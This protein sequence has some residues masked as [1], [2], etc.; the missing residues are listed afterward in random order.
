MGARPAD[1]DGVAGYSF[2]VWAPNARAVSV[3]GDFNQWDGR[4]HPLNNLGASGLWETFVPGL[5]RARSTSSRSIRGTARRS[6]RRSV[7]PAHRAA[8]AHRVDDL[9]SRP[10][11]VARRGLD[12]GAAERG[13]VLD[14]PMSIY[15]VHAGSW[16]R[17]PL[18]SGRSLTWRELAAELVPYVADWA[19]RTS[20]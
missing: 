3:V 20:S 12:G 15:E 14:R 8:A 13:T 9:A 16:R 2:V 19:S 6:P 18:R 7:R 1:V 5:G 17:N 11:R 10:A 4:A